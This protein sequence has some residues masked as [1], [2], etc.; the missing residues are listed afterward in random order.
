MAWDWDKLKE[1]QQKMGGG[2]PQMDEFVKKFKSLKIPGGPLIIL[3]IILIF[4]GASTIYT[5]AVDEVGIVQR[6]GRYVR[7]SQPGLNFKLPV[8]IEKV[9]KVK[10]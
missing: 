4:L 9:T 8:G 10:V 7:T 5:I 6:F 3:I 2:P 1:Q